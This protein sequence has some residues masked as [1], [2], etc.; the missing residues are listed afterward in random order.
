MTTLT[1]SQVE[2]LLYELC[3]RLGFCLP[4]A[5]QQRLSAAP[6]SDVEAFT[7]AVF[8]AE[9]MDPHGHPNLRKQVVA[10]VAA[11]FTKA[12]EGAV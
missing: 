5:D 7:D 10:R 11:H 1:Q 12:A 3:V 8:V 6:P 2:R 4:I 9:R